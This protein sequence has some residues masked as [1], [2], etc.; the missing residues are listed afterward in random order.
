MD[1]NTLRNSTATA[2]KTFQD[3]VNKKVL[4]NFEPNLVFSQFGEAPISEVGADNIVWAKFPK[5]TYTS[6][7][8]ELIDGV[9]PNDVGFTAETIEVKAKQYGLYAILTDKLAL[10]NLFNLSMVVAGIL[11]DNLARI[12]DTVIQNEVTDN[13]INRIYAATTAGGARA[14][15]RA[16]IGATHKMFTYDIA[17]VQTK[18]SAN[19]APKFSG[20]AY[21]GV[22]HPFVSH[23]ITTESGAGGRLAIKQYTVVGQNDIYRNEIG[24][25]HGVRIIESANV[26]SYA[27]TVTVYP[28]TF[29][30]KQ[31]YGV[32][33]LQG[34]K[35]IVKGF[36]SGG[37][38]D[39]LDQRMTIGVKKAFAPKILQQD[40][41][42]V[43]ESAG[44]AI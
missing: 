6:S 12:C 37:T 9:T 32:S 23:W 44:Y 38:Q 8:S 5:L 16:A 11:G 26:K 41:I 3:K 28:S 34:M 1:T 33:E 18:L 22:L 10:K 17:A 35:T 19:S 25:I 27:S 30:G 15:N 40:S 20:Q 21:V 42:V 4:E 14:A 2:G 24:M 39:P 31:A 13:A 29:F 7:Q 36:G 43:F